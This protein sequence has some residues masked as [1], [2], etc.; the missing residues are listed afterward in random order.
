MWDLK[1]EVRPVNV[2]GLGAGTRN[3]GDNLAKI[4]RTP[5]AFMCQKISLLGS[6]KILHDVLRRH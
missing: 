5:D 6:K 3:L 4:P 2:A 1:A